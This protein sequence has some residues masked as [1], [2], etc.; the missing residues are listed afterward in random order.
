MSEFTEYNLGNNEKEWIE[1]PENE[2]EITFSR[3]SGPGGQ[4]Y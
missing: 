3:S 4:K 1:I 2:Y